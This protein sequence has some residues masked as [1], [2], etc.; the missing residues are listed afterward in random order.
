MFSIAA[1]AVPCS[2]INFSERAQ[3]VLSKTAYARYVQLSSGH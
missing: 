2:E 1:Y 3:K